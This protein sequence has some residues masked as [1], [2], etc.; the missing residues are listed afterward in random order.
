LERDRL[1]IHFFGRALC[2]SEFEPSANA[3]GLTVSK[4]V[5]KP[6]GKFVVECVLHADRE[7][8]A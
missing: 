2:L 1:E 3:A 7:A 5:R 4:S 6:S 8:D